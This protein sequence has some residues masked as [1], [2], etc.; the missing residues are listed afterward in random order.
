[1]QHCL[2]IQI[3][4]ALL[5]FGWALDVWEVI[6]F[7]IVSCMNFTNSL[8]VFGPESEV[9]FSTTSFPRFS[10]STSLPSKRN[11]FGKRTA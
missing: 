9:G 4:I 7:R 10:M 11:S 2:S 6:T 8:K 5:L 3:Q 1:M